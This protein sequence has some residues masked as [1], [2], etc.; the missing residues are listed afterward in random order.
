M[1]PWARRNIPQLAGRLALVTGANSGL[2]W[3]AART[4][5]GK[6]ATVVMACRNREQ[7]ERARRA[8][9]GCW[10]ESVSER[11]PDAPA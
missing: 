11:Q 7:A 2:G 8:D 9:D 1:H 3:Q 4:L 5:A 10:N 6:G